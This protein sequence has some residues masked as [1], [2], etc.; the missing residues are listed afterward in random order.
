MMKK[1]KL[2]A[3]EFFQ[4][5][6]KTFMLPV[7]LLAAMGILLGIGAAFTGKTTISMFPFLG[8]PILQTIFNFMIKI[9]LVAFSFLPLM[10]AVAI[11]LGMARDNKEIAAFA[12][13]MGY[14][15]M[16]LGTSFCLTEMGMLD[17]V[18]TKTIMGIQSIDTGVLGALICGIIV[19]FIHD[20]FQYVELPDAFSFFSGTRFVAIV[21]VLIMSIVGLAVPFVWPFF[22]AGISKVGELIHDAGAFGPFLFGTGER[23][24]L[25][26]GLHHILVAAIRFT[27]AGGTYITEAGETI[28]GALNIFYN[29]FAQGPEFVSPEA[30]K[31][32]SQGKMPTFMFGLTGAAFAIYKSAYLENRKKIKGLLISAVIAA[33]V[34]GITEPIE[35]IFLFIAP[36][37]YLFHAI[38]TGLGFMVMGLLNVTIGNTDGNVIDFFIFGVFQGFWTKWFYVIPVGIAWFLIYYFV[39]KWYIVKF[40]IPTPGRDNSKQAKEAVDNGDMAGYTAKVMLEALGG[41]ENI[42]NLDNC[43]TRLRLIV[44]DVNN[45][46]VEAVKSAGA[47]EVVKLS[48]TNVQVIIGPKVQILKKQLQKLL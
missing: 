9:S 47:M 17:A 7:A 29:Q 4:S 41:K 31:F 28:H 43:I 11:P 26:F 10:F 12:G 6:G 19:F 45:I 1:N 18:S 23:L 33:A 32:L 36:V 3:W 25:P 42:V 15:A 22:A 20:K 34:G 39:F 13:L 48:D 35:F 2:S 14:I 38:M 24:L 46:D 37:L 21:T 44:K 27:E 8:T 30:T 16:L 5:L 40:N